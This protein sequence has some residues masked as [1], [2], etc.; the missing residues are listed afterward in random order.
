MVTKDKAP[1]TISNA[2]VE[3]QTRV[4]TIADLEAQLVQVRGEIKSVALTSIKEIIKE[5]NIPLNDILKI[6]RVKTKMLKGK[7][8][9]APIKYADPTNPNNVWSGKGKSP[10]WIQAYLNNGKSLSEFLVK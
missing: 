1:T 2:L 4:N 3:V 5:A 9:K 10:R 6:Y 8:K 7:A